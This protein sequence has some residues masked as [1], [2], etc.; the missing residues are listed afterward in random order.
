MKVTKQ[1]VYAELDPKNP[2][3]AN[4][5]AEKIARAHG[6][7]CTVKLRESL[8]VNL[9]G[10]WRDALK[11]GRSDIWRVPTEA[12]NECKYA[13][14]LGKDTSSEAKKYRN[15]ANYRRSKKTPKVI[16]PKTIVQRDVIDNFMAAAVEVEKELQRLTDV[17]QQY[18]KLTERLSKLY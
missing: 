11:A 5:L 7:G 18:H 16:K 12:G 13:Y 10:Y 1:L 9:S 17:E 14:G 3:T 15:R 2:Q 6:E 8:S 4:E